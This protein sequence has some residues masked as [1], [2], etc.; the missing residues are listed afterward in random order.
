MS[1]TNH[2]ANPPAWDTT[3]A[4]PTADG[5]TAG[6]TLS[7]FAVGDSHAGCGAITELGIE[8][9]VLGYTDAD[10]NTVD[11]YTRHGVLTLPAD[12]P[13]TPMPTD[14]RH[15][16][17]Y[18]ACAVHLI[19]Q[20]RDARLDQ[21]AEAAAHERILDQIRAYAIHQH[22]EGHYCRDG[23]NAFLRTFGMPTYDP[24]VRVDFTITGSYEVDTTDPGYAER[25]ARG[26]LKVDLTQIDNLIDD[27]DTSTV[28]ITD[29]T[30]L[31]T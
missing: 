24:R 13:A 7:D 25:D 6:R 23:L 15:L 29:T 12:T 10:P 31:D 21:Q 19:D 27:T 18:R 28:E 26:Y 14:D 2:H 5:E 22:L 3:T 20:T 30:T 4:P 11:I 17:L 9:V 1:I 8:A 16:A